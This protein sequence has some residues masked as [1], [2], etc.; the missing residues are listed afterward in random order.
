MRMRSTALVG[1]AL[2][3]MGGVLV[4]VALLARD[5]GS[6]RQLTREDKAAAVRL[7]LGWLTGDERI[8]GFDRDYPDAYRMKGNAT[9][10]L[11]C[12]FLPADAQVTENPRFRRISQAEYDKAFADQGMDAYQHGSYL[13]IVPAGETGQEFT[14]VV[15]NMMNSRAGHRYRFVFRKTGQGLTAN[16]ELEMTY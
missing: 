13:R 1:V 15:E 6:S 5:G 14:F 2:L 12:D 8:P 3:A 9:T 7:L 16:G 4:G 10:F 11:V